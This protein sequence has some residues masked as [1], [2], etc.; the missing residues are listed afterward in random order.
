MNPSSIRTK[1]GQA[2]SSFHRRDFPRGL[3]LTVQ[4]LKELGGQTA[5]SDLRSDFR[6]TIDELAADPVYKKECGQA[7]GYQPGKER[8]LGTFLNKLYNQ[9][10]GIA[11]QEDHETTLKRKLDLDHAIHEGRQLLG[12]GKV[13]EADTVFNNAAALIKNEYS[14]YAMMAKAL[15]EARE[16]VR[17]LGHLRKGLKLTPNDSAMLALATECQKLR[18]QAKS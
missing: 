4:A 18:E 9:I 10:Q 17:A 15:M 6:T 5:P 13:S 16:Y 11:G 12:Q 14:A 1:L 7:L 8:E 2:K 3:F